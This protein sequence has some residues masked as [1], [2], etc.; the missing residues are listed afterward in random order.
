MAHVRFSQDFDWSPRLHVVIAY[1]AGESYVVRREC[2]DEAI[3]A[4]AAK[5]VEPQ[6]RGGPHA[7]D[8]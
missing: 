6:R 8:D 7:D 2:A 5:E 3:A 4:G 1:K